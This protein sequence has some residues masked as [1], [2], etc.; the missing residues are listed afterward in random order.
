M[1]KARTQRVPRTRANN[2]WTEAA[3]WNFLRTGLRQMSR[4]WPPVVRL[5]MEAARRPYTGPNK[6]RKWEYQCAHCGHWFKGTEVH[7]D[8]IVPCG[9]LKSWEEFSQFAERLFCEIDGL[10]V[11][12]ESCHQ[13]RRQ[14][15]S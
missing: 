12:C 15:G 10:Q 13:D 3:F 6:R 4:R 9:S 11:L 5:A 7:V 8:H 2:E 14:E 1:G